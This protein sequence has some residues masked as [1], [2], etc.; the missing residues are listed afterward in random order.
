M[1]NRRFQDVQALQREVKILTGV[2]GHGL[3]SLPLGIAS[4]T[5][6]DATT[7]KVV[8]EDKY[9]D[10]VGVSLT[11]KVA[12]GTFS[13]V[14]ATAFNTNNEVVFTVDNVTTT[15]RFYL[16]LFLKNTSVAR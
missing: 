13:H 3:T 2:V 15:C 10:L 11:Q 16:T 4:C 5:R 14:D 6:V 8:L 1:A 12:G 7:L 9:E